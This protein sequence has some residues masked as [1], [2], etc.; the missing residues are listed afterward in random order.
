MKA[1]LYTDGGSRGNP[2]PAAS[3]A[4]LFDEAGEVIDE[5]MLY[6]GTATNNVA[7]YTAIIIGLELAKA[8]KITELDA[9]MDSELAVKQLK[10]EYKVKNAE[11]AKLWIRVRELAMGFER[12]TF[13]HVR[14]EK[15]KHADA[16]VNKALDAEIG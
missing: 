3:G 4:V 2:G 1:Q 16:L 15:N 14:R 9:R 10:G 7:E 13:S 5:A 12:V 8:H 11:L 6:L